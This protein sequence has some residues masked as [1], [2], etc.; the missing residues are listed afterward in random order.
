MSVRIKNLFKDFHE[1]GYTWVMLIIVGL[2]LIG[3]P[4]ASSDP[5][6]LERVMENLGF[7]GAYN[8]FEGIFPDY[9]VPVGNE[10]LGTFLAG[11][12]GIIL[13]FVVMLGLQFLLVKKSK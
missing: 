7:E 8:I 12:V 3:I 4:L 5:D 9:I 10:W 6:G 1:K 13:I 11:L 2:L